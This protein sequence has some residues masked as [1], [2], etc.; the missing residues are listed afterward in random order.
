MKGKR[1]GSSVNRRTLLKSAASFGLI[2]SGGLAPAQNTKAQPPVTL[3]LWTTSPELVPYYEVVATE[4]KGTNP[5][6]ELT[7]LSAPARQMERELTAA[8]P[9]GTG[10]TSWTLV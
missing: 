2:A 7:F 6:V 8:I 1:F 9:T 5:N 4:Y 3:S 10:P